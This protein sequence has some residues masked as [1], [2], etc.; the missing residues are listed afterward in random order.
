V[1][2]YGNIKKAQI[3]KCKYVITSPNGLALLD[4]K[5][6]YSKQLSTHDNG[7]YLKK[8][9][10]NGLCHVSSRNSASVLIDKGFGLLP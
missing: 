8:K 3:I 9:W 7:K 10:G 4:D 6:S 5:K 2:R 1:N